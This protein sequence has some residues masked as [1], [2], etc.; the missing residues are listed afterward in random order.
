MRSHERST[1]IRALGRAG[2]SRHAIAA[3]ADVTA[4][5]VAIADASP[6][7]DVRSE[8][9]VLSWAS[10]WTGVTARSGA[11]ASRRGCRIS[12]Q[13]CAQFLSG[14]RPLADSRRN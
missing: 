7:A 5:D 2:F 12:A 9:P 4:A 11:T 6:D 14:G 3:I 8:Q 13:K 10:V 1:R